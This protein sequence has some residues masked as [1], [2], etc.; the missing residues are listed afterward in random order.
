MMLLALFSPLAATANARF[1]CTKG[2][3]QAGP[4]CPRCHG[5]GARPSGPASRTPCCRVVIDPAPVATTSMIQS[6]GASPAP[7]PV[8]APAGMSFGMST[9]AVATVDVPPRPGPHFQASSTTLRL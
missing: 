1:V 5:H 8:L 6:S 9:T 2:M 4:S 7:L 3:A